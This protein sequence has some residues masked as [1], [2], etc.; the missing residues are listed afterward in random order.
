MVAARARWCRRT[1]RRSR[2]WR[3]TARALRRRERGRAPAARLRA[4]GAPARSSTPTTCCSS[5]KL[6]LRGRRRARAKRSASRRAEVERLLAFLEASAARLQSVSLG[7]HEHARP[8]RRQR[9]LPCSRSRASA[10]RRGLRVAAVALREL[11]DP[12]LGRE[13]GR[14]RVGVPRASFA[15]HLRLAARAGVARRGDGAARCRRR[16][17]AE[18]RDASRPDARALAA[19]ERRSATAGTTRILGMVVERPR[20]GRA[21]RCC[22]QFELAPELLRAARACSARSADARAAARHR[23][24]LADREGARRARHRPDRRGEGRAP[25]SRSRRSRAPTRRSARGCALAARRRRA[26]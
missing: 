7:A 8:D 2:S 6:P 1:C 10:R 23:L 16:S 19:A 4:R 3:A 15:R 22:A 18:R 24:R 26:W 20:G 11:A 25:C 17:C 21:P 5:S 13:R 9:A 14:V 12:A